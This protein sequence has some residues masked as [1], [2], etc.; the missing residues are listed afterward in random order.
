MIYHLKKHENLHKISALISIL[1][2]NWVK[3]EEK[4]RNSNTINRKSMNHNKISDKVI[5][6]PLN[7]VNR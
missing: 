3:N 1:G 4:R 7:I 2:K 5:K 6:M